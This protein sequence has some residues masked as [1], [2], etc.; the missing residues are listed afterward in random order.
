M[1]KHLGR[2]EMR[3][4]GFHSKAG[5]ALIGKTTDGKRGL[6]MALI[7]SSGFDGWMR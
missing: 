5:A 2:L 1:I 6:K 4:K 7:V 3:K